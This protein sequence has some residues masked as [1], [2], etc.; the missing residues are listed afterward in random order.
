[1]RSS[2]LKGK[3]ADEL[4]DRYEI[5]S[6]QIEEKTINMFIVKSDGEG[7]QAIVRYTSTESDF[8]SLANFLKLYTSTKLKRANAPKSH[9]KGVIHTLTDSAHQR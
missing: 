6:H 5:D 8:E 1:M 3:V 2:L 7:A 4:M 9:P